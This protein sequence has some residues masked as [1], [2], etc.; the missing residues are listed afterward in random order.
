V[1]F[2]F[3]NIH[4]HFCK[5]FIFTKYKILKSINSICYVELI[6]FIYFVNNIKH[7][8]I[9]IIYI[10]IKH[11]YIYIYIYILIYHICVFVYLYFSFNS[12]LFFFQIFVKENFNISKSYSNSQDKALSRTTDRA[13]LSRVLV[14]KYVQYVLVLLPSSID[15][16]FF[17]FHGRYSLCRFSR[18]K[19]VT[20]SFLSL[21]SKPM[22]FHCLLSEFI[23]VT[24]IVRSHRLK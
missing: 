22:F 12:D 8:N 24:S 16:R 9:Y 11:V 4:F 19:D 5:Y 1:L 21:A 23:S 6:Y 15:T 7:I 18:R 2:I 3:V 20:R 13:L 14:I 17:F 10:F